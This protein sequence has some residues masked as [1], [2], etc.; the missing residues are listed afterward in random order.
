[1][2]WRM[3]VRVYTQSLEDTSRNPFSFHRVGSKDQAIIKLGNKHLYPLSH[4]P[5]LLYS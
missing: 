1:M 4:S 3:T 5:V 2:W